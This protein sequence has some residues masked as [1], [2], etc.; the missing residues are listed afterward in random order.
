[1]KK[2]H[3]LIIVVFAVILIIAGAFIVLNQKR[4]E[5]LQSALR[6]SHQHL[7][8]TGTQLTETVSN[9]K[10][11]EEHNQKLIAYIDAKEKQENRVPIGFKFNSLFALS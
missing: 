6:R 9:Q 7:L 3:V 10:Q 8:N 5:Q 2:G 11:L 4:V 1:M